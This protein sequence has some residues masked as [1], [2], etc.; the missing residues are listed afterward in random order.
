MTGKRIGIAGC[1]R[2]GL[3]MARALKSFGDANAIEVVGFD[4]R[5]ANDFGHFAPFMSPSIEDF[6]CCDVVFTVVRDIAQTEALL[7]EDQALLRQNCLPRY[8]IICST[9]SPRYVKELTERVSSDVHLLDAPMSGAVIAAEEARLSF[10]IGG[11]EGDIRLLWPLFEAMGKHL[12]I[13][14]DYGAGMTAKVLNNFVAASSTV[15]TRQVLDWAD[16]LGIDK[17]RLL[18]LMHVSSGQTWLGS[19]FEAIEFAPHGF[20][21]DNS[22]GI[23]KKDVESMLD[24]VDASEDEGLQGAILNA[25]QNLKPYQG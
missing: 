10:M 21:P 4:I 25:L 11:D 14:G 16:Q 13:M 2:M 3:P 9:L 5:P 20:E 24:A 12:H 18:D 7:F 17:Q 15:A 22:I 6:S 8:L 23:L 19:N 1:G